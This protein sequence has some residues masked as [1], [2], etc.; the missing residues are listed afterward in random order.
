MR[1]AGSPAGAGR[2]ADVQTVIHPGPELPT[3]TIT[4][5]FSDI[6]GS[7]ALLRRLGDRYGEA[8][9]AQRALLRAAFAAVPAAGRW[10]P[11]GTA[12]S[13]CSSRPATR[14]AAAWRR[15]ARWPAM[16]G[17]AGS[18]CGSGWACIRASRPGTRTATSG[19][20][21][22][23]AAR[24]AAAAH[25]GQV[26]LSDATRQLAESRLPAGCV[27]PRPGLAPAEGHRGAGAYLPAGRAPG[28]RSEFPPLK[29]LGAPTSLPAPMTPLVGR[30]GDLE[31]LR[32]RAD[33]GRGSGW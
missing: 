8:L 25:G 23:R 13:W 20:D 15:S 4:M 28:C 21:V 24:I 26:V 16:T 19:M 32:A 29:S 9:S 7:T 18:R 11:R 27:A 33:R 3:G 22:H 6:E 14:S 5:L 1:S 2:P 30:D 31:Q 17:P 10:A 12:S